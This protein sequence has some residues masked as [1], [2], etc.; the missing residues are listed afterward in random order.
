MKIVIFVLGYKIVK[1]GHD[2]LVRGVKGE[3]KFATEF[4]GAKAD[5]ASVSPGLLFLLLGIVLMG[6]SL[7]I[8]KEIDTQYPDYT[9][10]SQ[11]DVS[12]E[13]DNIELP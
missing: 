8:D 10:N 4:Q 13:I 11:D 12:N 5:L 6:F 2:L 9:Q 3:F 7:G 1:L